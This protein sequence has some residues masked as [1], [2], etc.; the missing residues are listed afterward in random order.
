MC[1]CQEWRQQPHLAA[2]D[3]STPDTIIHYNM[4]A[5]ADAFFLI[6]FFIPENDAG[7]LLGVCYFRYK[8]NLK[9]EVLQHS[10]TAVIHVQTWETCSG[11]EAEV[12]RMHII[13]ITFK[14]RVRCFSG[15]IQFR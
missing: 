8:E 2:S 5:Q 9:V 7:F 6:I 11:L 10:S 4:T 13:L 15:L 1:D 14:C 3:G 12:C